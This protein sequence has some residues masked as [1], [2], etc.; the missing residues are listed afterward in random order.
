MQK[1]LTIA[2][3][4]STSPEAV[5]LDKNS[6][7]QYILSDSSVKRMTN[8]DG[9]VDDDD[10]YNEHG[11]AAIQRSYFWEWI[12]VYGSFNYYRI[13]IDCACACCLPNA[14]CTRAKFHLFRS[15]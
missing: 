4:E 14:A 7:S 13:V 1:N 8:I 10:V 2:A 3:G 5:R 9:F 11:H 6:T 12:M 15:S